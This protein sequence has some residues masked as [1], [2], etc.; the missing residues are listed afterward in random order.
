MFQDEA[1]FGRINE[2]KACWAP[3]GVRPMVGQQLVREYTYAY[4]AVSPLDGQSVF[5]ILPMMTAEAM[6]VFL[7]EVARR[8]EHHYILMIYDGAP[9][10]SETAL[11]VPDNMMTET[12]PAHCP[13][14]NPT[15][16]I[17][18]EIREK[19]FPNLIFDSMAAVERKLIES[20]LFLESNPELVQSITG[21]KWIVDV[22]KRSS[23]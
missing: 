9:C 1:R 19:F 21:F 22:L 14:L 13:E 15:E 3:P 23:R 16:H 6:S 4:G 12:L 5:L 2:P 11:S 20:L 10:H 7:A 18:D 17:W 8:Y